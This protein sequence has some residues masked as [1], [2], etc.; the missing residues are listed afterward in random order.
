MFIKNS[1]LNLIIKI[2]NTIFYKLQQAV[3]VIIIKNKQLINKKNY[4]IENNIKE[5]KPYI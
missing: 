5:N 1:I 3:K 2:I 4:I